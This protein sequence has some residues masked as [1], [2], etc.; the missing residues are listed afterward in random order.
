MAQNKSYA[1]NRY[2]YFNTKL[3][4]IVPKCYVGKRN[5]DIICFSSLVEYNVYRIVLSLSSHVG[6]HEKVT[7]LDKP[8]LEWTC[9]FAY[10][11][12][13]GSPV[14]L[15]EAKGYVTDIFIQNMKI[16]RKSKPELARK[17]IIAI[18]NTMR[19]KYRKKL[20]KL[21]IR[22]VYISELWYHLCQMKKEELASNKE[23]TDYVMLGNRQNLIQY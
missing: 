11:F 1:R 4:Q 23:P 5:P 12:T 19:E 17:L 22:L 8:H 6:V 16:F 3:E 13:D 2:V 21:D 15:L 20:A 9:D 10:T 18:P 14:H 7:I